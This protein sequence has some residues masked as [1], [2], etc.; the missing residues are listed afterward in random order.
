MVD[1]FQE[2]REEPFDLSVRGLGPPLLCPDFHFEETKVELVGGHVAFHIGKY[3]VPIGT[4][5]QLLG[6]PRRCHMVTTAWAKMW[7]SP[8]AS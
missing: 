7:T 1:L 4:G 2:F 6:T 8:R 3:P 5:Q